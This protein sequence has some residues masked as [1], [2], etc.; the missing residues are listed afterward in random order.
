MVQ[1]KTLIE[2]DGQGPASESIRQAWAA[3]LRTPAMTAE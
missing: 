2:F 1:G 3:I